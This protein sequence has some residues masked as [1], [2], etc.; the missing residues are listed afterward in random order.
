M[1][2]QTCAFF[3]IIDVGFGMQPDSEVVLTTRT[4]IESCDFGRSVLGTITG[5]V[6]GTVRELDDRT[7]QSREV[8][9]PSREVT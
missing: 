3:N 6:L 8:S 4:S 2:N 1:R 9:Q 5:T 7:E